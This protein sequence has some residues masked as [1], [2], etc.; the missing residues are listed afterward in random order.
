VG[1]TIINLKEWKIKKRLEQQTD[2]GDFLMS[3]CVSWSP[4]TIEQRI[5]SR[6]LFHEYLHEVS[7]FK[8]YKSQGMDISIPEYK[9]WL[10]KQLE[11]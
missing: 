11:D 7:L 8:F 1:A 6:Y 5:N 3:S 4:P 10:L 2:D 9:E